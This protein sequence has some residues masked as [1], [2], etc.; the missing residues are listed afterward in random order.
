MPESTAA[1]KKKKEVY[2]EMVALLES[3]KTAWGDA[4]MIPKP[5]HTLK[6]A[7]TLLS[8]VNEFMVHVA[9]ILNPK[10]FKPSVD[11]TA[12]RSL[13][14]YLQDKIHYN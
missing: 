13:T 1:L 9:F 8:T 6:E 4:A 11:K 2:A 12:G 14:P 5:A 3:V 7:E 10:S